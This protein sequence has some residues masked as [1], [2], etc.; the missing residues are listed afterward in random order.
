[1]ADQIPEDDP[2]RTHVVL[3]KGAKVS[4]Y[5]IIEKIGAGGM[6][7]V[8]LAE[9]TKLKRRVALKFM[10]AHLASDSDMRTRFT[11]EAQAA[12]KL[13]H[14]NIVP[15]YEVGESLGRPYFAM[16]HIEGD[17]LRKVVKS[18][19]LTV[20]EA[21]E[22]TMQ[23]C[24]GLQK[25]H[26]S[27]VVHRDMK[28]GNIVIDK[29]HR[30]RLLDFGLATMAGDEKLT[31]TGSTLGTV[32]YMAP[33]QV[34]GKKADRRSDL[35]SVGVILYEM[36]TGRR[37]FEGNNDAAVVKAITDAT[38]EPIARFKSGVT[39]QLQQVIDKA[40][41]KD[42]SLRYQHSDEML[43]DL[44]RLGLE[45]TG[46][47][48]NRVVWWAAAA[49]AVLV[50]AYFGF[51]GLSSDESA[52]LL[53]KKTLA[54]LPFENLGSSEDAYFA[55]GI[56]DEITS[57]LRRIENLRVTS[58]TSAMQY[59]DTDKGLKQIGEELG[60]D[61]VLEGTIRWDKS[62]PTNV[63]RI[64]PQLIK[65]ADGF[66]VWG[67]NYQRDLKEIFALQTEIADEIVS[68]L[69]FTLRDEGTFA[70]ISPPTENMAAYD[71]FLRAR[72]F[73]AHG[74]NVR[75]VN[76]A[77]E[78]LH[79]AIAL[80]SGFAAAYGRLS[81]AHLSLY[82]WYGSMNDVRLAKDA[83]DKGMAINP[84]LPETQLAL[85]SYYTMYV[86]D[87]QG[88]HD[89]F[90]RVRQTAGY[91]SDLYQQMSFLAKRQG[92]WSQALSYAE[93]ALEFDP[94]SALRCSELGNTYSELRDYAQADHYYNR[95]IA[96]SPSNHEFYY[97]KAN[98]ILLW[99]GD[100]EEAKRVI[101]DASTFVDP[102]RDM[103]LGFEVG[104]A[105]LGLWRFDLIDANLDEVSKRLSQ[106]FY[107]PKKHVYYTS[108]AQISELTNK[109]ELAQVYY[110]SARVYLEEQVSLYP[111][112]FHHRSELGLTYAS[113]GRKEDAIREGLKAKELMPIE[114]CHW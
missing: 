49:V 1:M 52:T 72:D 59:E 101:E 74:N 41:T 17:S 26:E 70:E 102:E 92:R 94:R 96:L 73:L 66:N 98:N 99:K 45:S 13:D 6:G 83:L 23:I 75:N 14:P 69:G 67:E 95:A 16:A 64:T 55:V 80:D 7:E 34:S 48:K 58:R 32:G 29:S 54:V 108:Q 21:V 10:P 104:L 85:G 114:V 35:F 30:P 76:S 38:P 2:T 31:K 103:L 107:G 112:D 46:P 28:P 90:E 84:G 57:R 113:L 50:S 97:F 87:Y 110:D 36:L 20:S 100:P 79:S 61:Y 8:Y 25:A 33:E 15:V 77:I 60:V 109:P 40:L 37:P 11:R 82:F 86:K 56:T 111:E 63:V 44:K 68:A 22:L 47:K 4:H 106:E 18:G 5:Q 12:A 27:G 19:K 42:P 88:A 71:F 3:T 89:A 39:G 105:T 51:S 43:A 93:K 81:Y 53:D 65:V 62:G 24:E 9:D 78:M 91:S